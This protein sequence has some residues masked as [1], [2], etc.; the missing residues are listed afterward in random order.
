MSKENFLK[1]IESLEN[2]RIRINDTIIEIPELA[3]G[4][5]VDEKISDIGE[6]A[7]NAN[8]SDLIKITNQGLIKTNLGG[9]I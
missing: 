1:L 3:L 6:T 4:G 8:L 5:I 2:E 9:S 7:A